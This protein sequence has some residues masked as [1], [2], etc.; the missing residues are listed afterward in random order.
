MRVPSKYSYN[1]A[2]QI[3]AILYNNEIRGTR[4]QLLTSTIGMILALLISPSQRLAAQTE[5]AQIS[6]IHMC[7]S[8]A[9]HSAA[10]LS[11]AVKMLKKKP[12]NAVIVSGD[13]GEYKACW[14]KV[15]SIL[16]ALPVPVYYVPGNH[17]VHTTGVS[18]YRTVFGPD[19]YRIR[20][21]N[22]DVIVIDS[23]LLGNFDK[24]NSATPPPLPA[25]TQ[26]L[27]NKMI[28]WLTALV[29]VEKE[30]ILAGHVV[31]AVQH[32]PDYRASGF[33]PG[34][35]PYWTISDPYRTKE[36]NILHS[37][38]VKDVLSGH[39]HSARV[40]D[41][42]NITWHSAPSTGWLPWGGTLG[43]AI[44]TISSAGNVSTQFVDLPNA[45]P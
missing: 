5:I 4:R 39:W 20:V 10:N 26:A 8:R 37:L 32:I 29:P 19:Y 15:K 35:K 3:S 42:G 22:V 11:T 9:P 34:S 43:F 2:F 33:P 1:A 41:A 16:S 25:S 40:F 24:Y 27:S 28:A 44:H 45:V 6:D 30:A 31:I 14:L 23:Q 13:M 7:N 38:G 12:I 21:K 36:M 18:I 17:D